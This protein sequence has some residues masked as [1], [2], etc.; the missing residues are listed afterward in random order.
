MSKPHPCRRRRRSPAAAGDSQRRAALPSG[1]CYGRRRA[2]ASSQ[3]GGRGQPLTLPALSAAGRQAPGLAGQPRRPEAMWRPTSAPAN[4]PPHNRLSTTHPSRIHSP[5]HPPQRRQQAPALLAP[6]PALLLL[7]G[8]CLGGHA[9]LRQVA[10]RVDDARQ[11]PGAAAALGVVQQPGRAPLRC[12]EGGILPGLPT[13]HVL[14]CSGPGPANQ[15][16]AA[17]RPVPA[18]QPALASRPSPAQRSPAQPAAHPRTHARTHAP[19]HP[20]TCTST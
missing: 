8:L 18:S 20:P 1:C 13:A 15:S 12:T 3:P 10:L 6:Q 19:T 7:L 14:R 4:R 11:P 9:G 5:A 16:A 17:G 2:C